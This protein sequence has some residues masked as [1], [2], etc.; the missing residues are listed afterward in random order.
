MQPIL[1]AQPFRGLTDTPFRI[2]GG[3]L[4]GGEAWTAVAQS[5]VWLGVM[6]TMGQWGMRQGMRRMVVARLDGPATA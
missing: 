3:D 2:Y 5:V 4:S 1:M 6:I